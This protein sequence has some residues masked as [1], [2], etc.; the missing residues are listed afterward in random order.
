MESKIKM[1]VICGPTATGKTELGLKLAKK[2]NGE[3]ISADSRQV[4]RGMDIGTGKDVNNFKFSI[5]NFKSNSNFKNINKKFTIGYYTAGSIKIWGLDIVDPDYQF[6]V[7]EYKEIAEKIIADIF[8]R[9]KL[10]IIVG[11]TGLYIKSLI[12]PLSFVNIP[13]DDKLREELRNQGIKELKDKLQK[14]DKQRFLKMN[15]SDR[16]NPRRLI[17][18]IEIC[19]YQKNHSFHSNN[20]YHYSKNNCQPVIIG[21]TADKKVLFKRIEERVNKRLKQ[22][23]I[24]E[25]EKLL[26]KGYDWNLT[27][28]SGLGYQEFRPFFEKKASLSEVAEKWQQDEIKYAKRQLVWFKKMPNIYWFDI[29]KPGFYTDL[30]NKIA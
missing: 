23:I 30:L 1:I 7:G 27:S 3:I 29:T 6:N 9:G 19:L 24:T 4:Y 8:K 20:I 16:N 18:A 17:R 2:F 21:L 11:G 14:I 13:P 28:M 15:N 5:F 12:E 10:P 25:I 26:H 22:G